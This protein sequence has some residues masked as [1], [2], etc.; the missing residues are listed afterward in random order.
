MLLQLPSLG[1]DTADEL[2]ERVHRW[3]ALVGPRLAASIQYSVS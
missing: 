1:R 3:S 2:V